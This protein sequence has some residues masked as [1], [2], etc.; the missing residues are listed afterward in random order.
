[1][2]SKINTQSSGLRVQIDQSRARQAPRIFL[3]PLADPGGH[4][5]TDS[6]KLDIHR[7]RLSRAR[8]SPGFA[9]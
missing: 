2:D 9:R 4:A 8:F 1:M 7:V 5:G 3:V 6:D